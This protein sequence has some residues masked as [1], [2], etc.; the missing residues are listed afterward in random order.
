M[1]L[2]KDENVKNDQVFRQTREMVIEK[3][4][5][6]ENI[7]KEME[8]TRK[9]IENY[10]SEK[11]NIITNIVDFQVR[12]AGI[13]SRE[14]SIKQY[15][16]LKYESN[17]VLNNTLGNLPYLSLS[18]LHLIKSTLYGSARVLLR[19]FLEM[20]L[21]SKY[22]EYDKSLIELWESQTE[23]S[24]SSLRISI[25]LHV[26]K[27]LK[28]KK[29]DISELEKTW[30][31]LC[32]FTHATRYAQQML[33]VPIVNNSSYKE[34]ITKWIKET[35]LI[36][37]LHYTLD[38]FFMLLCMNCHLL[39]GHLGKKAYRWYLGYIRDP[40]NSFEKEQKLKNEIKIL[41][42]KYFEINKEYRGINKILKKN[43]FQYRQKWERK[44]NTARKHSEGR[45]HPTAERHLRI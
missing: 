13:Y 36:P 40:L 29:I 35:R 15:M 7:S 3:Q 10:L 20:L 5:N 21:I 45:T 16:G 25:G 12:L 38:L 43:I 30:K 4:F 39:I 37:N 14:C 44:T 41:F 34:E 19:Q 22:S 6:L 9:I 18:I 31:Q 26:F 33:R 17:Y 23:N 28:Q 24:S 2:S 1:S 32:Q 8:I 11:I 27:K 42:K